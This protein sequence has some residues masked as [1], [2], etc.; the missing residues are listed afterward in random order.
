MFGMIFEL[1]YNIAPSKLKICKLFAKFEEYRESSD[2]K[3]SSIAVQRNRFI[4]DGSII[5]PHLSHLNIFNA[6]RV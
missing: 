6:Q 3:I 1:R 4:N 5:C 2:L